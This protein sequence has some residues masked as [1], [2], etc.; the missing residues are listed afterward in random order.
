MN[1]IVLIRLQPPLETG[2]ASIYHLGDSQ[3]KVDTGPES[4]DVALKD[5]VRQRI[6]EELQQGNRS[7]VVDLALVKWVSSSEIGMMLAW[8]R[9]AANH[10][11]QLVLANP[12]QSVK[13]VMKITKLDTVMKVFS[14][15]SDAEQHFADERSR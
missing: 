13:E 15:L 10:E 5:Y 8:Y 12:S 4:G 6:D 7:F 11:G 9:L 14:E 3:E 2:R 1:Q